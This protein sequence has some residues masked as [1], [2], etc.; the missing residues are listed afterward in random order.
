MSKAEIL[1]TLL[2]TDS[3]RRLLASRMVNRASF[4]YNC[5]ECGMGWNSF[6]HSHSEKE[7]L[8]HLVHES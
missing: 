2:S 8:L 4:K 5:K 7:C 6:W 1:V 3:G